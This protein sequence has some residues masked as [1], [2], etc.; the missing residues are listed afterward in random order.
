[1]WWVVCSAGVGSLPK[2]RERGGAGAGQNEASTALQQE[3][4]P[5]AYLGVV[6]TLGG[7]A[8]RG[9]QLCFRALFD[10]FRGTFWGT[11]AGHPL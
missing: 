5:A 4:C 11:L 3:L 2:A 10:T 6:Q 9:V 8:F 1:M 7:E